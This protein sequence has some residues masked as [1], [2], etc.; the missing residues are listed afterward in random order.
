[1]SLGAPGESPETLD[2]TFSLLA[3]IQPTA[4]VAMAG[5]RIFPGTGLEK[6]AAAE[7]AMSPSANLLEP[8]FYISPAVKDRILDICREQAA[9][10]PNWIFPGLGIN[11]TRR[12]QSKLRKIGVRGPLW[13]HMKILRRG[14]QREE[15]GG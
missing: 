12:L 5:L 9:L 15:P 14:K 11:V 8:V 2:E 3:E 7:G 4:V 1:L 10:R 6:I 13:E